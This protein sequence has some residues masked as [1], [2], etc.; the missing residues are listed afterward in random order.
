MA[1]ASENGAELSSDVGDPRFQHGAVGDINGRARCG[2]VQD[3]Q[4]GSAVF[5]SRRAFQFESSLLRLTSATGK[6][7]AARLRRCAPVLR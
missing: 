3:L 7:S 2:H 1:P 5:R 6:E 4:L